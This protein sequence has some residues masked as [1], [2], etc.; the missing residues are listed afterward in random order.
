M[1]IERVKAYFA[2][3]GM[4]H[5]VREFE[6]S[7]ATVELAAEALGTEGARIAKSVTLHAPN[8]GCIMILCAGDH[9][10]DNASFKLLKEAT[11]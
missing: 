10:I 5:R 7:S 4:E 6:V 11:K 1:S 3:H 8:G 9:K 2:Q